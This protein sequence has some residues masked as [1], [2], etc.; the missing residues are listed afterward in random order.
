MGKVIQFPFGEEPEKKEEKELKTEPLTE[1]DFNQ[2]IEVF[3][4][5]LK[6]LYPSQ[7]KDILGVIGLGEKYGDEKFVVGLLM[8]EHYKH[9]HPLVSSFV[10]VLKGDKLE[11]ISFLEAKNNYWDWKLM[12]KTYKDK[13]HTEE[14]MRGLFELKE[15]FEKG[16]I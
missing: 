10:A 12:V 2:V 5:D 8:W 3:K 7:V 14:L 1:E 16:E 13:F 9:S 11:K 15:R 6:T 4:K